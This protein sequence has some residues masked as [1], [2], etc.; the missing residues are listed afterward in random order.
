MNYARQ[1]AQHAAMTV[2]TTL[3]TGALFYLLRIVLYKNL[4]QEEYGLFYVVFS[5]AMIF[6]TVVTFGF[7]PGLVPFVTRYRE[8]GDPD[9][10]KSIALGSLVPQGVLTAVVVAVFLIVPPAAAR[11]MAPDSDA[12]ALV[13]ILAHPASP[14]LFRILALHAVLVLMFKCGQQLLLGMQAIGWRNLA[15]LARAMLC[16]GGAVI[17]LR[18]GWGVHATAAAYTLGAL[19]EAVVLAVAVVLAFPNVVRA[20]FTWRPKDVREVFDSGKWLSIGFGGIVVFSSVDTTVI[21]LVRADLSDAAAYQIAL[22]TITILYSLMIAA[23]ISLLPTVRTLWLRGEHALLADGVQ[24]MYRTA[25]GLIAPAGVIL[26]CGSDVLMTTLFGREILNAPD[27]FNVLAVGGIAFFLA[28]IN[29]HILAGIDQAR[30]AGVAVVCGL[31][32]DVALSL[33]LTYTFGIRG[34]AIAGV[35]GYSVV[36]GFSLAAIRRQLPIRIPIR[37]IAGSAILILCGD[38]IALFLRQRG[39]IHVDQP[40]MS[41]VFGLATL[42]VVVAASEIIGIIELRNLFSR[43]RAP[44]ATTSNDHK[45]RLD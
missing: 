34:T 37:A 3:L 44:Y 11:W 39:Y 42:G 35:L 30:A 6:Q 45:P 12:P 1:F 27:A 23:G 13:R 40:V 20:R 26:A 5:Y 10:I 8:E 28:Y 14:A 25:I 18:S 33:P 22:P 31:V 24:R 7:D 41:A 15:D 29:L 17:L 16:L 43:V 36:V 19:A 38:A 32:T 2:A 9:A 4:S 21:S